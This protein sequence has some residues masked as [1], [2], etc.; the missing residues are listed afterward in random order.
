MDGPGWWAFGRNQ[1][2]DQFE[3]PKIM[4]PDYEDNP[5]AGL[6]LEGR[7]YS[8]T[9]Y[10]LTLRTNVPITLPI[11]A[12]LLNSNLLFWVLA[13][14]GTALQRGFV[15][16]MPQYLDRLPVAQPD[17]KTAAILLD[18][19]KRGMKNGYASVQ[20]ELNETVNRLYGLT[21]EEARVI[22]EVEG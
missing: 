14:T 7:F 10:C 5:A 11:L 21:E 3:Q 1:N 13:K 12:G 17:Q 19:A 6:D 4:L 8:I 9:A 22:R 18:I 16:F 20:A 2:L 15:R